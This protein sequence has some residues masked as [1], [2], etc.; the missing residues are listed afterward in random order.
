MHVCIHARTH[1]HTH[2]TNLYVARCHWHGHDTQ[3]RIPAPTRSPNP[4][5]SI[6]ISPGG[7]EMEGRPF[8]TWG[9]PAPLA[10]AGGLAQQW[11]ICSFGCICSCYQA[12]CMVDCMCNE[13]CS[14]A[15][16]PCTCSTD[17]STQ[18]TPAGGLLSYCY[19]DHDLSCQAF[20]S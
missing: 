6:G 11:D 18:V 7:L 9:L 2:E 3:A 1:I 14:R 8:C 4:P 16:T 19:T 10:H 5:I 17:K 13:F 12:S 15:H 20:C